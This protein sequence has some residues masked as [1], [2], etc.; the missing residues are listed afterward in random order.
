[1]KHDIAG[2]R[3]DWLT[4]TLLCSVCGGLVWA[5]AGS[6]GLTGAHRGAW[7]GT[8]GVTNASEV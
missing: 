8:R 4:G 1:M 7:G 5:H 3:D 2:S 6:L